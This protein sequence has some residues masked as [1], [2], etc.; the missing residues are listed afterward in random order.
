MA[1]Y[2]S[3]LLADGTADLGFLHK[4]RV[5]PVCEVFFFG[6]GTFGGGTLALYWSP[7]GGTTKIPV[8]DLTN[9]AVTSTQNFGVMATMVTGDKNSDQITLHAVLTGSTNPSL[10]VGYYDNN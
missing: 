9:V 6:Y 7:D 4:N 2:T 1:K 10:I 8:T 5:Y 3:T